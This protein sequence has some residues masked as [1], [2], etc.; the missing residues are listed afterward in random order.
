MKI[1]IFVN[2]KDKMKL[3]DATY[4]V[5]KLN[6]KYYYN[7]IPIHDIVEG[8]N[9]IFL[10]IISNKYH[11]IDP[12]IEV[13]VMKQIPRSELDKQLDIIIPQIKSFLEEKS[14]NEDKFWIQS[15]RD[16]I[17]YCFMKDYIYR[18]NKYKALNNFLKEF[19]KFNSI[20]D[21]IIK[22]YGSEYRLILSDIP[23]LIKMESIIH[24]LLGCITEHEMYS[25]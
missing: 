17:E 10:E 20:K 16:V 4:C 14:K 13:E 6:D 9:F 25:E 18:G 24:K 22:L 12:E 8:N 1:F 7:N 2:C 19:I 15:R 11:S 3:K 21:T 5:F 23:T